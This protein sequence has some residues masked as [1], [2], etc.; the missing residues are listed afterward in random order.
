MERQQVPFMVA[1]L[2]LGETSSMPSQINNIKKQTVLLHKT[3]LQTLMH[4]GRAMSPPGTKPKNKRPVIVHLT[5]L[6]LI[7][8]VHFF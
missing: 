4:Y 5:L 1:D 2:E 7:C 6:M 8:I 3:V